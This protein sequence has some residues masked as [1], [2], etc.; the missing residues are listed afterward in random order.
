MREIWMAIGAL[1]IA[2][3]MA[4]LASYSANAH[5]MDVKC[6]SGKDMIYHNEIPDVHYADGVIVFREP[7]TDLL[8]VID[9]DCVVSLKKKEVRHIKRVTHRK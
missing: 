7:K 9:A 8:M 5:A 4:L 1:V 3:T 2:I 6:F